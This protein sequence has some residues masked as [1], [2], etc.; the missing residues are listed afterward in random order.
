[1]TSRRKEM[2]QFQKEL[3]KLNSKM[4]STTMQLQVEMR[5]G[6]EA[7]RVDIMKVLE[8]VMNKQDVPSKWITLDDSGSN[9]TADTK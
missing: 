3:E 7:L 8:L 4:D 2:G 9:R 6:M 1:M 5:K